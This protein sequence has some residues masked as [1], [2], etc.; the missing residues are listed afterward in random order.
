MI[1]F[2]Q[3]VYEVREDIGA[4]N[5]ALRVCLR[6]TNLRSERTIRLSTLSA[7]ALGKSES[8]HS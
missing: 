6:I 4:E 8:T 3:S 1:E 7:T 2:E 5:L